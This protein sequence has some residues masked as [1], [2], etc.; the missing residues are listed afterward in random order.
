MYHY[1]IILQSRHIL[2]SLYVITNS[3]KFDIILVN[4]NISF[5][6]YC[7]SKILYL[8]PKFMLTNITFYK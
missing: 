5:V 7:D 2:I 3:L 4:Y 6:S 1:D 8:N